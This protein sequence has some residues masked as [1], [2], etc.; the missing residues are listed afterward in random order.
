MVR[1]RFQCLP[2]AFVYGRRGRTAV[3]LLSGGASKAVATQHYVELEAQTVALFL[4]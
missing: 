3:F 1:R 2:I 4:S